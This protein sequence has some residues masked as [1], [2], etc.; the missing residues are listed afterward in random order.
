MMYRIPFL[1][2]VIVALVA[3]A[4]PPPLAA[5]DKMHE[6]T[7]LKAGDGKITLKFQGDVKKHVHDVA[8]DAM[9]TLD[10]K[11]A[12]LEELKEG[13]PVKVM[14]NDKSVIS[15]IEAKSKKK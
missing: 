12:K 4:G 3:L 5:D 9:I 8:P 15:M 11:Q 13:F 14:L 1:A 10:D 7:V 6:A 2:V